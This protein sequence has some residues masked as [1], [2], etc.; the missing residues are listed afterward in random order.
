[1]DGRVEK[2]MGDD[3]A[4]GSQ[5]GARWNDVMAHLHQLAFEASDA[6]GH[7]A[8]ALEH[9]HASTQQTRMAPE[10]LD[11]LAP[12][13]GLAKQEVEALVENE[14][15]ELNIIAREGAATISQ[16]FA[17]LVQSLLAAG[18]RPDS[19]EMERMLRSAREALGELVRAQ[20]KHLASSDAAGASRA[21]RDWGNA[22]RSLM[23]TASVEKFWPAA[24]TAILAMGEMDGAL[25]DD[26][27]AD[28]RSDS[29]GLVLGKADGDAEWMRRLEAMLPDLPADADDERQR[30]R[31]Q[32]RREGQLAHTHTYSNTP[33]PSPV[34]MP[35]TTFSRRSTRTLGPPDPQVTPACP[36]LL[37]PP[38]PPARFL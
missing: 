21:Q 15:V 19:S 20:A 34:A 31:P 37:T 38:S 30:A 7:G 33:D 26:R 11:A 8:P 5:P 2:G 22:R 28:S 36:T 23:L 3:R 10:G 6:A 24:R 16:Q 13:A 32:S 29:R 35:T 18:V 9:A 17:P 12:R 4:S 25:Y 14:E 1:M 27:A